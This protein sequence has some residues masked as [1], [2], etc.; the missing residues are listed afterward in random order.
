MHVIFKR[1]ANALINSYP[2]TEELQQIKIGKC[3][4]DSFNYIVLMEELKQLYSLRK[5]GF[6]LGSERD[7]RIF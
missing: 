3:L 5:I 1:A 4:I 2:H 6:G 7:I